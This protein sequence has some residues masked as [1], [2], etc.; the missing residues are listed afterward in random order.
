MLVRMTAPRF[1]PTSPRQQ[2]SSL[3]IEPPGRPAN[4]LILYLVLLMHLYSSTIQYS[5]QT[6]GM[7]P[8]SYNND[9]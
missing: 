6:P 7:D 1:E 5:I 2:V 3:P 9:D 4:I 8:L